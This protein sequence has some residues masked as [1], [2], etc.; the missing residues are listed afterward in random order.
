MEDT[1]DCRISV[2][3]NISD[4]NKLCNPENFYK[5]IQLLIRV[6]HEPIADMV[7]RTGC[8]PKCKIVTYD[9]EVTKGV[10]NWDSNWTAMVFVQPKSSLVEIEEEYYTFD[11]NDLISSIGGNLGLFLGWSLLSIVEAI[12]LMFIYLKTCT[13]FL[14]RDELN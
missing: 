7:R 8:S 4:H 5:Y 9:Y 2:Y 14:D 13:N 10:A 6:K 1:T 12:G 11:T 3:G